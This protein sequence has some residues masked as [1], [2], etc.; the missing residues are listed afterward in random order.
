MEHN[1]RFLAFIRD[2]SATDKKYR[3]VFG[4]KWNEMEKK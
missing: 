2:F 1:N 4:K 3:E